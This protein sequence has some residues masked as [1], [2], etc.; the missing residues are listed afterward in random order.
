ML[1]FNIAPTSLQEEITPLYGAEICCPPKATHVPH[2][3]VAL[4][5]L[6]V[7]EGLPFR[8]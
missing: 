4:R 1:S 8:T 7:A 3:A 5:W 2:P 6:R